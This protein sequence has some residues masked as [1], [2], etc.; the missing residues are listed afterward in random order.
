MSSCPPPASFRGREDRARPADV[1]GAS[2]LALSKIIPGWPAHEPSR[3]TSKPNGAHRD[4]HAAVLALHAGAS[5]LAL[6]GPVALGKAA[7]R[8]A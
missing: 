1:P 6:D 8:D 4:L 7:E 3:R 2:P 5:S